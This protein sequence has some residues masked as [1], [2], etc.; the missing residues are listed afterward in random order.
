MDATIAFV[1]QLARAA[2]GSAARTL[3]GLGGLVLL[4]IVVLGLAFV[5]GAL[6]AG[7]LAPASD[8]I[9]AAPFRWKS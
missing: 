6:V 9:L 7:L 2:E 1:T 3:A 5:V 8:A 4:A